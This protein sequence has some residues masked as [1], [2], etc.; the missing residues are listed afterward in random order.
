MAHTPLP[1]TV[2]TD[3]LTTAPKC[4]VNVYS[5]P[6]LQPFP[7]HT[8]P[9]R[10]FLHLLALDMEASMEY[11]TIATGTHMRLIM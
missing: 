2:N 6:A 5:P 8:P 11:N 1:M 3:P 7:T 10:S 9:L 4:L